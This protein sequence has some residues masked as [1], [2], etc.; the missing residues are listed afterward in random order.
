M[1]TKLY[2]VS[3]T[4]HFTAIATAIVFLGGTN[5]STAGNTENNGPAY[6]SLPANKRQAIE[7]RIAPPEISKRDA[8]FSTPMYYLLRKG[9]R[10]GRKKEFVLKRSRPDWQ[11]VLM[12]DW[13]EL[14]LTSTLF[15]TSPTHWDRKYIV[16]QIRCYFDLSKKYGLAV[17]IRLGGDRKLGGISGSGWDLHPKNPKN[18]ID[19]YVQWAKQVAAEGKGKVAYYV[20]GDEVNSNYWEKADGKGGTKYGHQAPEEYRWTP[21]IYLQVFKQIAAGIK[22]VDPK[23]KVAMFGMAGMDWPYAKELLDLGF[24]KYG[25]AVSANVIRLKP[26]KQ[27]VD[28][29]NNVKKAAPGFKIYSNGVGYVGSTSAIPNPVNQKYKVYSDDEQAVRLARRMFMY[30]SAGWNRTPYYITVRQWEMPDGKIY[31]HWY[32]VFGITTLVVDKDDKLTIKRHPAWYAYQTIANIFY[33]QSKTV[34]AKFK[35]EYSVPVDFAKVYTRND[36]EC[37]IVLWNDK[38]TK[39]TTA[40]LPLQKYAYPVRISLANYKKTTDL[41]YQMKDGK[42]IIPGLKVGRKP[43][44]IRLL[45]ENLK[46]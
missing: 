7:K 28:F 36:Y 13:A 3:F 18:R 5:M 25:D 10:D 34:P 41:P 20:I 45:A 44:I 21:K 43:V 46:R 8:P 40:I 14:G 6:S 12:K 39:T 24:A 31:P 38:E 33:S 37:L 11:E 42:L 4:R 23:A 1:K 2:K 16:E 9:Y 17:G 19:E 29:A 32:G 35:V 26:Y 22:S 30:Y 27:V 15:L